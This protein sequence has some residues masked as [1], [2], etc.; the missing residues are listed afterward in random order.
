M[1]FFESSGLELQI[2]MN[3]FNALLVK[4]NDF[5]IFGFAFLTNCNNEPIPSWGQQ[6]QQ[7]F[8]AGEIPYHAESQQMVQT[9]LKSSK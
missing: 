4:A 7:L 2:K 8:V 9:C 1:N 6:L 3:S 5:Q